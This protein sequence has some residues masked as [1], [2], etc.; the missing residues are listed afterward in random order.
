M[1]SSST[2]IRVRYAETDMMGVAYYSNYFIWFEVARVHL[3]DEMG[4]SYREIERDG[5]RL[6]VLEAHARY[7]LPTRLD[8]V[9]TIKASILEKPG[10]VRLR[11]D[12]EAFCGDLKICTGYTKHAFVDSQGRPTRAPENFIQILN[13]AMSDV[14]SSGS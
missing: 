1:I 4:H 5:Y 13:E 14:E 12:Y 7:L 6:P 2:Q 11:I 10:L 8:D 3:L 9:V